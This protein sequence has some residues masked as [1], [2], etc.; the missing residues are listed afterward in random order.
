MRSKEQLQHVSQIMRIVLFT[1]VGITVAIAIYGYSVTGMWWVSLGDKQFQ[2]LWQSY[3]ELRT[4]LTMAI[5]PV[6]VTMLTGVYMLQRILKLFSQGLFFSKSAKTSL[7]A[8]SW[9]TVFG[10][11]YK[12]FWPLFIA[13]LLPP[14]KEVDISIEPFSLIILLFLPVLVHLLTAADELNTE[15]S[16]FI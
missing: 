9:L 6:I 7:K 15:N 14:G 10:V 11:V 16:E 12:M 1:I 13:T 2:A 3:P 5:A 4:Y 8:L